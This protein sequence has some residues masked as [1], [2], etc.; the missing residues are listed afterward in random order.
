MISGQYYYLLLL[1]DFF[2]QGDKFRVLSVPSTNTSSE[3]TDPDKENKH[4]FTG[5]IV[6]IIYLTVFFFW[7]ADKTCPVPECIVCGEKL[8]NAVMVP[9]KLKRHFSTMPFSL[10]SKDFHYFRRLLEENKQ[11]TIFV[12]ATVRISQKA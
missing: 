4:Q 3:I 5:N 6:I 10:S 9:D 12:T 8:S 1:L 2:F 11:I 7:C